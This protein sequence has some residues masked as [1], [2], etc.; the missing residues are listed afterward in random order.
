VH[1][2]VFALSVIEGS[3]FRFSS[4]N[5]RFLEATGL[6]ETD[7]L[8]KYVE[9]VIPPASHALVFRK[10]REA[11]ETG[12]AVSWEE[13][14]QYPSGEK[15][16]QVT[17]TPVIGAD[18]QCRQLIGTVH[19]I[20]K[21]RQMTDLLERTEERW[22]LA[23]EGSGAGVSDWN[24][25]SGEATYS[26]QWKRMLGYGGAQIA[27]GWKEWESR[28]HPDDKAGVMTA[29]HL[30]MQN[31]APSV[32]IEHR[33][34]HEDGH[35]ISVQYHG[36][37][38]YDQS[39]V[40]ES[41]IGTIVDITSRKE[42]EA[43]TQLY[44]LV[45]KNSSEAM[46]VTDENGVI[47]AINRAFAKAYDAAEEEV[48]GV[49]LA[50]Y[51]AT[52]EGAESY[53]KMVR[54]VT[55]TGHWKGEVWRRKRD[56]SKVT[57][58]CTVDTV[59]EADGAVSKRILLFLDITD[60]KK[61][62]DLIWRQANYDLLTALPNRFMFTDRLRH[63]I[64]LALRNNSTVALLFIDLDRFKDVND[65]L[66]HGVGD[67]LLVQ[68]A[69]RLQQAAGEADT[70]ARLGGDEFA[71]ILVGLDDNVVEQTA[72]NLT[73]VLALPYDLDGDTAYVSASIGVAHYP[74]DA[75]DADNLIKHA[76]QA[77]YSAKS[78]GG[79]QYGYFLPSM[80][81]A[82]LT[83]RR[84]VNHL[85]DAISERQLHVAYQ[86]I[87]DLKD[88]SVAKA[89]A[90]LRWVHPKDGTIPP[91]VFI[92][93]AEEIGMINQLGEWVCREALQ[94]L[95]G[96]LQA[97][98]PTFKI[99]INFSPLQFKGSRDAFDTLFELI[100]SIGV[101]A[102]CIVMELTESTLLGLDSRLLERFAALRAHGV[103][104]ALDDF[105]TGYSS[106]SYMTKLK[107]DF[108]KIDQIFVRN[109]ENAPGDLALCETMIVLAHKLGMKVIAE[110][111]ETAAQR[112]ILAQAGCD[113][114]QGYL[115]AKPMPIGEF[116]LFLAA[117]S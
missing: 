48:R 113:Y 54:H 7:V 99:S 80:Q 31:H 67:V 22:R 106:L 93:L 64:E 101:P 57:E 52:L 29:M 90:L 17:V 61:A 114:A 8:D 45:Y 110:G 77:M 86:P 103:Q 112:R 28:I 20:T 108:L 40:P 23:L 58:L 42:A 81:H 100:A 111:V 91:N 21:F 98:K 60:R 46:I 62:E 3:R 109:L 50:A 74:R 26:D 35:W 76:D 6:A 2:I 89:E 116:D 13:I 70:V 51:F 34:R 44:A 30:A 95:A 92:P 65:G 115:F 10:Y 49:H 107:F 87:V 11:I 68:V 16:G 88:G 33:L 39:R 105:G 14:S 32:S 78:A 43:A 27:P 37:I 19:D 55:A 9:D 25:G 59:H 18:N 4:V 117:R 73:N 83:R 97:R 36:M 5:Q 63:A 75:A 94:A 66:G 38:S 69:T 85:H 12:K 47:V 56:G 96:R 102:T 79:N 24:I 53:E 15:I 72:G 41:M 84:L 104:L 82:A 71:V 1:D